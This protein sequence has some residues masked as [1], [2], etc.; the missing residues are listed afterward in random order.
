[1]VTNSVTLSDGTHTV[2]LMSHARPEAQPSANVGE[3]PIPGRFLG[4]QIQ[5]LA[6]PQWRYSV[7]GVLNSR[8][9]VGGAGI[10]HQDDENDFEEG[11]YLELIK[12]NTSA[13]TT[14]VQ[15]DNGVVIRNVTVRVLEF[16]SWRIAGATMNWW[17]YSIKLIRKQ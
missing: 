14:F 6:A 2:K 10:A 1:M 9:G 7:T 4:G 8:A 13:D 5:V 17:G 11:G 16:P 15:T 12:N 3:V